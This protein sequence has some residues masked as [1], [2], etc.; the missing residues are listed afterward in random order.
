M[1]QT[2]N[3]DGDDQDRAR[4]LREGSLRAAR[5]RADRRRAEA[6][7]GTTAED[8]LGG[9]R[10]NTASSRPPAEVVRGR[11]RSPESVGDV[12]GSEEEVDPPEDV[13]P[14]EGSDVVVQL[15]P[16]HALPH[17]DDRALAGELLE[18]ALDGPADVRM[19]EGIEVS[20]P[21]GEILDAGPV[22]RLIAFAHDP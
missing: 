19:L 12:E 2:C 15:S 22:E 13:G 3:G 5:K 20:A 8:G 1:R 16:V 11:E 18:R 14:E 21:E 9:D 6:A 10:R 7:T 17:P 4:E